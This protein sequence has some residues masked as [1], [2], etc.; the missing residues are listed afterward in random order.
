MSDAKQ[1]GIDSNISH[2]KS[3]SG[4]RERSDKEMVWL[5]QNLFLRI[6]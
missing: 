4:M 5:E 3:L 1:H 6:L 2:H